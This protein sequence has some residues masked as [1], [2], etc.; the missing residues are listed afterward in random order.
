MD[1][2]LEYAANH[3]WLVSATVLTLILVL[4]FELRLRQNEFA[5]V[6]PQDAIRLMNQGALVLDL[7]PAEA[8]AEG[9]LSGARNFSSGD[10]LKAGET[11]KKY[12]EKS[13]LVYCNTG[14]LAASAARILAGQGFTK[15]LNLRGGI[16]GW[17]A[18]GL[19][20]S[21]EPAKDKRA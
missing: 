5:A 3:P 12:K 13:I 1:R 21:K 7:R 6:S 4:V 19:P 17:R 10:I 14:S 8:Y 2:L 11:L 15:V 20:L 18:E 9:H 16:A